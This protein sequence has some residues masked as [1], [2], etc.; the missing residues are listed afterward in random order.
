MV[1]GNDGEYQLHGDAIPVVFRIGIGKHS[2]FEAPAWRRH[3]GQ[4]ASGGSL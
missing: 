2:R 4:N 1:G 3:K